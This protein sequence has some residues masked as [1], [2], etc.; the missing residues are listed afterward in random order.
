MGGATVGQLDVADEGAAFTNAFLS[1]VVRAEATGSAARVAL[2]SRTR[3]GVVDLEA[4]ADAPPPQDSTAVVV[5][6]G[7][8]GLVYMTG[9]T[10]GSRPRSSS[11]YPG[12]IATP[13]EPSGVGAVLV[14]RR[15]RRPGSWESAA[16]GTG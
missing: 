15:G 12:M 8:L 3:D 4:E 7:N 11:L 5:G 16:S 9:S 2:A 10:I 1:E 13:T 14:H 6:S